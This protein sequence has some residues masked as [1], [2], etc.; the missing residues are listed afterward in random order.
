M[1][2]YKYTDFMMMTYLLKDVQIDEMIKCFYV[3]MVYN[4]LRFTLINI[5][6]KS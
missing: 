6:S 1:S 4:A 2:L 3:G 5:L